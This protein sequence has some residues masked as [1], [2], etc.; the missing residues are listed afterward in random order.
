MP[1]T[2]LL[3]SDPTLLADAVE[4]VRELSLRLW[5]VRAAHTPVPRLLG[6]ERCSCCREAYPCPTVRA[7]RG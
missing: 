6:G 2:V 1:P 3:P 4:R 5:A 7:T